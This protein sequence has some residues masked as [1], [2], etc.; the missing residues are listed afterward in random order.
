MGS[1]PREAAVPSPTPPLVSIIVNNYNHGDY[2]EQ[3]ISSALGQTYADVEVVVVDDGSTDDSRE[4][5][6]QF[7]SRIIAVLKANG[8]QGSAFNA[9]LEHASGGVIMFLDSDDYL[10]PGAVERVVPEFGPGVAKVQFRLTVVDGEG[11]RTG[12]Y[13]PP[14]APLHRGDV[15]PLLVTRGVYSTS[16]CS[17]NAYARRAIEAIFPV[18]EDAFGYGADGYVNAAVPFCGEVRAIDEQLGAYRIHGRN[19]STMETTG[20]DVGL[21]HYFIRHQLAIERVIVD[22]ARAAGYRVRPGLMLH[23]AAHVEA[24][25]ASLRLDPGAHPVPSDHRLELTIRGVVATWRYLDVSLVRKVADTASFLALGLFPRVVAS[26]VISW[27][28]ERASRPAAIKLAVSAI[29]R[30]LRNG[31]R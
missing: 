10:L 19:Y 25:L 1:S 31:G 11:H 15:R 2:L 16:V 29:R 12:E 4:V 13:P 14:D 22:R 30:L 7:G 17:G 28:Y 5:I 27:R 9:G 20:V 6:R 21:F 3:A 23:N 24:R 18:P 26:N 8:G